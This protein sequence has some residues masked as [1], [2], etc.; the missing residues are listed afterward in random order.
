MLLQTFLS[1]IL[2]FL[3]VSQALGKLK[4]PNKLLIILLQLPVRL[5]ESKK[6]FL[7]QIR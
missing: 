2:W 7:L 5:Q 1:F 4:L 3:V 6:N